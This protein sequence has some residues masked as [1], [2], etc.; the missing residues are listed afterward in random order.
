MY[1]SRCVAAAFLLL[2]LRLPANAQ[3]ASRIRE[4]TASIAEGADRE[5]RRS[6]ITKVLTASGI[7]FELQEA[8]EP[9]RSLTNI[10][11]TVRGETS[12][13]IL[14]GS[15]YDRVAQGN[16]VLDNGAS[17]AVLLNLLESL[18][19]R[20]AALTVRVVFFDLEES[21]LIGSRAYFARG[22][23]EPKPAYAVN[24]DI[25]GY[26]DSFFV[27][28]PNPAGTL[29]TKF[30]QAAGESNL[31]VRV[32]QPAQY[33]SSDHVSMIQVGIETLG[34]A[35]IDG[36]EVDSVLGM[37]RGG[38]TPGAPP[39]VLTII[40]TARDTMDILRPADVAKGAA[41]LERFVRTLN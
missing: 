22:G 6:A 26:G 30:Q 1:R 13:T 19:A 23:N 11:A 28:S 29:T 2:L 25:F 5:A 8:G 31:A 12:K 38:Q 18:K 4:I 17:C 24:L 34:I 14:L 9:G 35:L 21:G 37:V 33:P 32:S 36:A 15:H 27:A 3:E 39:R 7:G 16:G 40:H 41:T 20:P 10:V